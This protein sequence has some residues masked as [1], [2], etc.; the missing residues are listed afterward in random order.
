MESFREDEHVR[1][2]VKRHFVEFRDIEYAN[3]HV[4]IFMKGSKSKGRLGREMCGIVEFKSGVDIQ[5]IDGIFY[6]CVDLSR[7]QDC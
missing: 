3:L 2:I 4:V 5:G 1:M 6:F 7:I